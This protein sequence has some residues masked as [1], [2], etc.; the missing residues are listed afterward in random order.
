MKNVENADDLYRS[1]P[2]LTLTRSVSEDRHTSSRL[3]FGLVCRSGKCLTLGRVKYRFNN[4]SLAR[5]AFVFN[6]QQSF[7]RASGFYFHKLLRHNFHP[8][9]KRHYEYN[10]RAYIIESS[11]ELAVQR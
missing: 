6:I 2:I 10:V 1:R 5:Q 4:P 8:R 7:A 9:N 11:H 3:H